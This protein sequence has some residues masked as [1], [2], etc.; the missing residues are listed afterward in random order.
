LRAAR[1][2]GLALLAVL[3]VVFELLVVEEDLLT[4]GENK[5]G[6]AVAALQYSIGEFH[7]PASPKQGRSPKSAS[8]LSNRAGR[9]SL[10]PFVFHKQGPGPPFKKKAVC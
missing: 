9:D 10:F 8:D 2:L 6:S 5:L 1:A 3:G 7:W 4:G